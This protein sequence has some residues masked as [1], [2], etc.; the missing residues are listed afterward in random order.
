MLPTTPDAI[1]AAEFAK[2]RTPRSPEYQAGMRD[3]LAVIMHGAAP[4][5]P[6]PLGTAA[7]DAFLAGREEARIIWRL[8]LTQQDGGH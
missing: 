1:V 5:L 3:A 6:Y 8:R 4:H 2:P 7:A